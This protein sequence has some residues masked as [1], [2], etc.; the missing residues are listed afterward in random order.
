MRRENRGVSRVLRLANPVSPIP[1]VSRGAE[2]ERLVGQ[3]G[4]TAGATRGADFVF[5]F[6]ESAAN[7]P[8]L[9]RYG[10]VRSGRS[11]AEFQV[12]GSAVSEIAKVR[13]SDDFSA[14]P[15]ETCAADPKGRRHFLFFS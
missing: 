1:I 2:V 6:H 10:R 8:Q 3:P 11:S 13:G 5:R 4:D 12:A 14:T 15:A 9:C 7:A